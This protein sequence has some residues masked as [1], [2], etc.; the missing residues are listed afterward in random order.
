MKIV[1]GISGAS[2]IVYGKRLVEALKER[3][4]SVVITDGARRT[5]KLE[6]VELPRKNGKTIYGEQDFRA[7]F[8]S[9]SAAADV[10]I[11]CPC[12]M[13]TLSAVA[14]GYADNLLTRS[15]DVVIKEGGRLVLVLREMPLSAI[16]LENALKLARLGAVIMPASPGFYGKPRKIEDMIDFVV[17]RAMKAAGIENQLYKRWNGEG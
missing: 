1:V 6:R 16:H 11:V 12:S 17:G 5:A 8:A 13:K 4:P 7:Q 14:N 2:G 10:M 3:K 9:G 15:A